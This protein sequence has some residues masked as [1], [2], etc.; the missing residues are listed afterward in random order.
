MKNREIKF[1]AWNNKGSKMF[2]NVSTGT[3]V[4]FGENH[5]SADSEDCVFMQYTGLKDKKGLEIYEGDIYTEKNPTGIIKNKIE[6]MAGTFWVGSYPMQDI[7]D[8]MDDDGTEFFLGGE[9]IGNIYENPE[10]LK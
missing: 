2:H 10:L 8:D 9:I 6:F 7:V 1:R 5:E 4:V 3:I